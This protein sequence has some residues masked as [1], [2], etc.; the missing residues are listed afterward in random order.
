MITPEEIYQ[1]WHKQT[2][3]NLKG[4]YPRTVQN[5]DNAKQAEKWVYF[6]KLADIINNGNGIVDYKLYIQSLC[7]FYSKKNVPFDILTSQKGFKIYRNFINILN[8]HTDMN[9]IKKCIVDNINF[10]VN[11]CKENKI[12]RFSDYINDDNLIPKL[13]VHFNSG[14]VSIYFF[15]LVENIELTIK[16]YPQDVVE[17]FLGDLITFFGKIKQ[18]KMQI[19][20]DETLRKISYNLEKIINNKIGEIK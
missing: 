14:N 16:E 2:F 12:N 20:Q 9:S 8:T 17:D 5:F 19:L 13:I 18:Y 15:S 11:Y 1:E 10:I 4:F 7:E 3:F 6:Q